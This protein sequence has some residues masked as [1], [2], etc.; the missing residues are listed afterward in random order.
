M[1]HQVIALDCSLIFLASSFIESAYVQ[2]SK[3]EPRIL[4]NLDGQWKDIFLQTI[5]CLLRRM[6]HN[7]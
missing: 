6:Y 2:R 3:G 1:G 7:N 4:G 5:L